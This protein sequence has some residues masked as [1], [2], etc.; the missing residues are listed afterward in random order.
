MKKT[1]KEFNMKNLLLASIILLS[2]CTVVP[3]IKEYPGVSL[4][5]NSTTGGLVR[6]DKAGYRYCTK[7]L[8]DRYEKLW[9]DYYGYITSIAQKEYTPLGNGLYRLDA[10]HFRD[11]KVMRILDYNG[12]KPKD[13]K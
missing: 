13:N 12:I 1:A 5:G 8:I 10:Q 9:P 4:D 6:T 11:Y 2:G 7:T 3:S